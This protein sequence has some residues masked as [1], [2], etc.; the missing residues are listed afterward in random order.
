MNPESLYSEKYLHIWNMIEDGFIRMEQLWD[1]IGIQKQ[2]TIDNMKETY[3]ES[4]KEV[5]EI[6]I[7]KVI[8]DVNAVGS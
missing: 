7:N 5:L 8:A 1:E 3:I 4:V 2:E 6:H